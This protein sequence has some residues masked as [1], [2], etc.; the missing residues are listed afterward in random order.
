M[1]TAFCE[2]KK[3]P[4]FA[5]QKDTNLIREIWEYRMSPSVEGMLVE[6]SIF[7]GSLK[8]AGREL[9]LQ[10]LKNAVNSREVAK[11]LVEAFRM[12]LG[13]EIPFFLP[14]LK[15]K[16]QSDHEFDSLSDACFHLNYLFHA[17]RLLD[18]KLNEE[19]EEVLKQGW[20]RTALLVA[21][22]GGTR[23]EEEDKRIS[24]LRGIYQLLLE[25]PRLLDQQLLQ[26]G[27][28]SLL[29]LE[30]GNVALQ[31][32]SAGLLL[33]LGEMERADV[34]KRAEG[35]FYGTGHHFANAV[36]FL[37]G[38]FATARETLLSGGELLQGLDH[39]L[40]NVGEEEFL[41]IL[42]ELR[43]AFS[44]FNPSDINKIGGQ[45]AEL[46]QTTEKEVLDMEALDEAVLKEAERLNTVGEG[47]L[48]NI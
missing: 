4:D 27:L 45:V 33:G 11:L 41:A 25:H 34:V 47:L 23:V 22:L 36:S 40:Q 31:G 20:S 38:L 19:L 9:L 39:I 13:N 24:S 29:N 16:L 8:E 44:F 32:A 30:N 5:K 48:M 42:P 14:Q 21:T 1:G 15:E 28:E 7:G 6:L 17:H 3:G 12:G 18:F 37:K 2:L 10:S 26:G 35:F 46:Y 43:L